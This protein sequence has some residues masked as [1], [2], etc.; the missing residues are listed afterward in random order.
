MATLMPLPNSKAIPDS[1]SRAHQPV[2]ESAM[3]S[4]V[5]ILLPA[6]EIPT[7]G[8]GEDPEDID[9][10][11][12][13]DVAARLRALGSGNEIAPSQQ[14]NDHQ[15]YLC[16]VPAGVLPDLKVGSDGHRLRVTSNPEQPF[17]EGRVLSVQAI[18]GGSEAFNRD[19]LVNDHAT[20]N[21]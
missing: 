5:D 14:A 11:Q 19:L 12:V 7:P 15:S 9:D 21:Q 13:P 10:V 3:S 17:L 8:F 2:A 1:W 4:T 20:Q 6:S 16:Q 18:L